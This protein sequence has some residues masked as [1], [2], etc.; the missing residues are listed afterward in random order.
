MK[1]VK[2]NELRKDAF[3]D[4]DFWEVN[5]PSE[6]G[7]NR[8]RSNITVR[9]FRHRSKNF[10]W[11]KA[12]V[13]YLGDPSEAASIAEL[14]MDYVYTYCSAVNT[15]FYASNIFFPLLKQLSAPTLVLGTA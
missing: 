3:F 15:A 6:Y 1:K 14:G 5:T 2:V 12:Y 10:Y 7:N 13:E 4:R 11:E 9:P 8:A